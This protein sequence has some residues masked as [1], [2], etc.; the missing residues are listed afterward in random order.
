MRLCCFIILHLFILCSVVCFLCFCTQA[1]GR[2]NKTE[3]QE[4]K[5]CKLSH[6]NENQMKSGGNPQQEARTK[7]DETLV[8]SV[9]DR[10]SVNASPSDPHI[11]SPHQSQEGFEQ[12]TAK[13]RY[14]K[15]SQKQEKSIE[16][17]DSRWQINNELKVMWSCRFI[18]QKIQII[19]VR[20]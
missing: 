18:Q 6:K 14:N 1:F 12:R 3:K 7:E 9:F 20:R 11:I 10:L 13:D 4:N 19:S 16:Q 2:H 5:R 15:H 17:Y 8:W